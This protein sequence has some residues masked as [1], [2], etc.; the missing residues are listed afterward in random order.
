[1]AKING[2]GELERQ[3][4][5]VEAFG[6]AVNNLSAKVEFDTTDPSSVE[7]AIA[8]ASQYI[9]DAAMAFPRNALVNELAQ[10]AKN[11][12][13]EQIVER[14]TVMN[15][16]SKGKSGHVRQDEVLDHLVEINETVS[17]LQAADYQTIQRPMNALAR[18]IRSPILASIVSSLTSGLD[19]DEW[20]EAGSQTQSSMVGSAYL[21]WPESIEAELGISILLIYRMAEDPSFTQNFSFTFYYAGSQFTPTLRKMVGGVVVPFCRKFSR[22]VKGE[23][24][25]ANSVNQAASVMNNITINN[26]QVGSLQTGD[27]SVANVHISGGQTN[28]QLDKSLAQLAEQLRAVVSIPVHDKDEIL[29]LIAESRAELEKGK[30]SKVKLNAI[31]PAIGG[32]VS[33]ISDLGGAFSA[34]QAAAAVAGFA[35]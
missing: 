24:R 2:F 28:C 1:M 20:V 4:R 34:V 18:L 9:D 35:F 21:D 12:F 32:A 5:E 6:Q 8:M 3:L 25:I 14:A 11:H 31:L 15:E 17:E 29:S 27:S 26:S 23:L 19:L 7:L 33:L 10:A 22:Y 13:H 16:E 30:P